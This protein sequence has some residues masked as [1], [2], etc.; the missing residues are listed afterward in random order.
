MLKSILDTRTR[1][2]LR[3]EQKNLKGSALGFKE[4]VVGLSHVF[5]ID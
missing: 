3:N 2:S 1:F 4:Y 5:L